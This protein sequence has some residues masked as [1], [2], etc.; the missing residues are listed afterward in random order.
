M[1]LGDSFGLGHELAAIFAEPGF[2][3]VAHAASV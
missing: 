1:R 2:R 3:P